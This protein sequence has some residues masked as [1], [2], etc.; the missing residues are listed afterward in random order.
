MLKKINIINK[1]LA[2]VAFL[3]FVLAGFAAAQTL[4]RGY[5]SDE[6]LQKGMLVAENKDDPSKVKAIT[7]DELDRLKGVVVQQNDSPVTLSSDGQNI[8]VASSGVF[9]I[10]VSSENGFINKG[11]Y[12]SISSLKGIGMKA[13]SDQRIVAARAIGEFKDNSASLGQAQ[14]NSRPVSL[15][16]IEA[17]IEIFRNPFYK[18]PEGSTVPKLLENISVTVAGGPVSAAKMWLALTIFA[19]SAFIVVVMLYSGIKSSFVSLG[20]NPLSKKAV[21]Q[22][23]AQV[24]VMSLIVFITGL[25]GVYLLLKL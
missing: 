23:V 16:R 19:I 14:V 22:G 18:S 9:E 3:S 10:L 25:F 12:I 8:F 1:I 17:T 4:S 6:E 24:L 20:R 7:A 13:R 11:D 15:A 2:A 5:T 21:F